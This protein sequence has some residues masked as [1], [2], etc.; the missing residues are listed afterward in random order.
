MYMRKLLHAFLGLL[1]LTTLFLPASA[2]A[3]EPVDLL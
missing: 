2:A 1:L 3:V